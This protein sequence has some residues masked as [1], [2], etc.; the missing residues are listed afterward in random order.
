MFKYT[1]SFENGLRSAVENSEAIRCISFLNFFFFVFLIK[2]SNFVRSVLSNVTVFH[3]LVFALI[4]KVRFRC[5]E[6]S[7]H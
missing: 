7:L 3:I 5:S 2:I 4:C 1:D 6:N